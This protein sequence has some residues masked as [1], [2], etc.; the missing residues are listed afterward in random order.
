MIRK[1]MLLALGLTLAFGLLPLLLAL[2][3]SLV[4]GALGCGLEDSSVH[5]CRLLG[6]EIGGALSASLMLGWFGMITL[7]VS[8]MV[9]VVWIAAALALVAVERVRRRVQAR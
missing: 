3:G 4:A 8:G 9:L 5:S 7:P 1:L 6:L 2:G